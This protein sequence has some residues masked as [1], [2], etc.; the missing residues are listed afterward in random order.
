MCQLETEIINTKTQ[1]PSSI[2]SLLDK[3]NIKLRILQDITKCNLGF[4][5]SNDSPFPS[6]KTCT[7]ILLCIKSHFSSCPEYFFFQPLFWFKDTQMEVLCLKSRIY[8][9]ILHAPPILNG[10]AAFLIQNYI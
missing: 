1:L 2:L 10:H 9:F 3:S 8:S 7:F 5:A 4:W 6:N